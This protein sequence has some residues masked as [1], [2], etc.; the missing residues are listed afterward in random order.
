MSASKPGLGLLGSSCDMPDHN[1]FA[2]LTRCRDA[3][4]GFPAVVAAA[5]AERDLTK[6]SQAVIPLVNYAFKWVLV[7]LT[8][9][10]L[11]AEFPLAVGLALRLMNACAALGP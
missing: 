8:V 6:A 5:K 2:R 1:G 7:L 4:G 10:L 9:F 11:L 3:A